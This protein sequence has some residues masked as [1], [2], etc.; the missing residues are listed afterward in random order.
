MKEN[1]KRVLD[2]GEVAKESKL[3]PSTLRYYEEIGLI[4]SIGRKGLRRLYSLKVIEQLEFIALARSGGFSLEEIGNMFSADGHLHVDRKLLQ[5]KA[6]ELGKKI[7]QLQAIQN[8]LEHVANC[9][10]PSHLECP[11]FLRLL[12]LAKGFKKEIN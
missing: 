1:S 7:A 6:N 3:A 2:I 12:R 11:K 10:A 8:G 4:R 5:K 9:K